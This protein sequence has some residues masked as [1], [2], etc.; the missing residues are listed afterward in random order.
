MGYTLQ[1][2]TGEQAG[3]IRAIDETL[4]VGRAE[5]CDLQLPDR[6]MSRRHA[7]FHKIDD[8]LFVED[9]G[10]PN[11]TLVNQHRIRKSELHSGDIVTMGKTSVRIATTTSPSS[12]ERI[13]PDL[14]KP[15]KEALPPDLDRMVAEDYF[16]ALGLGEDTLLDASA[17]RIETIIRKTRNF[18]ILHEIS[19]AMQRAHD[20]MAMLNTVLD[21]VLKVTGADRSYVALV[22]EQGS[23]RVE[24]TR[25]ARPQSGSSN[26]SL[27]QT[28]TEHVLKG[29]CGIICSDASADDRFAQA[30][31]LFLN[32]TRALMASPMLLQNRVLGLIAVESSHM[33][34]R[35]TEYD[36]DLLSVVASTVG[37][38][39]DNMQLAQKR[40]QTIKALEEAQA[41]LLATQNRL[42]QSE[43]MAAIGRLATGIAHE[44]KNHLSPFML[45][46]MIARK[47]PE[48]G[49]IQE[50]AEIMLEAQQHIL[51]L[52]NEVRNFASGVESPPEA[53]LHSLQEV[54]EGVIRFL[55]CDKVVKRSKVRLEVKEDSEVHLDPG[56][57]RQ[58]LINLLR[59]A[60][61]AIPKDRR[62]L[63]QIRLHAR[64]HR[65][66]ID[67]IDNGC[68]I[69]EDI[70]ERV[71][72]PFFSTKG[73]QGLGLGLDISRKIIR[74]HGGELGFTSQPDQGTTFRISLPRKVPE[75]T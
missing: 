63:I 11:G 71:F 58:V 9:L 47:Y 25:T 23:E 38:A 26:A 55:Q 24:A 49:E 53:E 30:Q 21:L 14:I 65:A 27:S 15:V 10:S 70:A 34:A 33:G 32:E 17:A 18:A 12:P 7:R 51:D 8:R 62:G 43:Q 44:V 69:P 16:S 48:D 42:I 64:E 28:V 75:D 5:E 72:Q 35:F 68:G 31:S 50:S 22:D 74:A 1:V 20:P 13:R 4:I 6:R 2:L 54:I 73:Q 3:Q 67:V 66:L 46:N 45:A 29:R 52:V 61:Y 40:E 37:V 59:N 36:L 19:K 39:L 56:R 41:Q 60:A 57:I